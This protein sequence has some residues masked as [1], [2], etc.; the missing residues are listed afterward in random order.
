MNPTLHPHSKAALARGAAPQRLPARALW[1]LAAAL[2]TG[3]ATLPGAQPESAALAAAATPAQWQAP[4][5]QAGSFKTPPL[6]LAGAGGPD[7]GRSAPSGES[8]TASQPDN[9]TTLAQW[10]Q[11]FNDPLL[12]ELIDSAQQQSPTVA[13]AR[14][15]VEQARAL[16]AAR[17]A[18][19]LPGLNA[20]AAASRGQPDPTLPLGTSSSVG[21]QASWELDLFGA[22]A[23]GR[24]AAEARLQGAQSSWHDA[25]VSVAAEVGETYL[26]LRACEAQALQAQFDADSRTETARLTDLSAKAG[27]QSPANAALARA[28]AAQGRAALVQRRAS[29]DLTVKSLV[30]L[31]AW[32]EPALRSRLAAAKARLPQP[33]GLSVASVPALVLQQRPDVRAAELALL[34]AQAD[35]S[36]SQAQRLPRIS[37]SGNIGAAR[38]DAGSFSASGSVWSIGP[39]A[40]SLPLFDGG[41]LRANVGAAEARRAEAAAA[42]QSRLRSAVREVE[43]ALVN[44]QSTADRSE[45]VGVA[46]E[47]FAASYR[48]AEA[49]QKNGLASLFELEDA[50]RTAVQAQS[51]LIDLQR[52][53]V[54]AWIALYRAVGGGWSPSDPGLFVEAGAAR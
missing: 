44:L 36:Q 50:R 33:A 18:A 12:T 9:L 39:V 7:A 21:L 2:Q 49:R 14:S 29:C 16:R 32:D 24:D 37:L 40:V 17:G 11:Q 25:R 19:L 43:D 3:C 47:G 15:R 34:A 4:W 35:V 28:S 31:T 48:A 41:T 26:S 53:R 20:N 8:T 22:N 42:Y 38:F 54:A 13:A 23:A 45:D 5:P 30:A 10:W 27:F 52:E 6:S 46:T 51:A 1:L